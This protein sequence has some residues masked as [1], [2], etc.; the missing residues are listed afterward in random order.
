MCTRTRTPGHISPADEKSFD[1]IAMVSFLPVGRIFWFG[2]L[3]FFSWT[4]DSTSLGGTAVGQYCCE[5]VIEERT[6]VTYARGGF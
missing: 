1:M 2:F 3:A 6:G 4:F 5:R